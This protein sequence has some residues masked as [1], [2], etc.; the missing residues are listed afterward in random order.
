VSGHIAAVDSVS[1]STDVVVGRQPI[2]DRSGDVV[3]FELLYRPAGAGTSITGEQMTAQV[4]LGALTIGVDQLVGEKAMFCNA[5]RGALTGE[6]PVTL[7]PGRT[8]IEVLETVRIDD[9]TVEG[10]REL[11]AAGFRVAL[12]DF[13][14]TE[15]AERLLPLASIVKIDFQAMSREEVRHLADR[16]REYDVVLLAEKVETADDI[17]WAM[18]E[19]FELFQGYAI[20]RPEVVTGHTIAA[21]ALAHVQLAMTLLAEDLD[22]EEIEAI[23]RREPGLVVQLLQMASIGSHLGMRRQVRTVREA[24]VLL[25]TTRIRQ[26]V[27][28]TILSAQPGRTP[29]GLASALVRARM[30]ELLAGRRDC[31][32]SDFAFT[33]GLLSALDLLLGV[34]LDELARTMDIDDDL[35]SVAFRREGVVGALVCEVTRYQAGVAMGSSLEDAA[36]DVHTAAAESFAWA[37]PFVNSLEAAS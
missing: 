30:T 7:P 22:F 24:L 26:W 34:E 19:G 5:E 4:V 13:V 21:S 3:G 25:G 33:A 10:C 16:C 37:M 29:D 35:K 28:L 20:D 23:L 18:A 12:D 9:E 17:V 27:A 32:S 11:V 6:T 31:G 2:T 8:V 15:G 1:T 14:W 36:G